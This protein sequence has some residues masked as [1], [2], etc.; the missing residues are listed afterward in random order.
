V[1]IKCQPLRFFQ[2]KTPGIN[3]GLRSSGVEIESLIEVGEDMKI[4]GSEQ[5]EVRFFCIGAGNQVGVWVGGGDGQ[6]PLRKSR[7]MKATRI[8]RSPNTY[9]IAASL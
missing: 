7:N 9:V 6:T 2:P 4:N 3:R 5:A 1:G 8:R